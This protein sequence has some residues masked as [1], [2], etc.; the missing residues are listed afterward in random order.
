MGVRVAH[1]TLQVCHGISTDALP[2]VRKSGVTHF[3][4]GVVHNM[5]MGGRVGNSAGMSWYFHRCAMPTVRES[6][7]THFG[8][9]AVHMSVR[10]AHATL[11]V[12]HGIS[13]DA[14]RLLCAKE[15]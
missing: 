1:A 14:L 6:G 7:V 10:V 12:C 9:G 4:K 3:G 2:T 5:A 11:Q 15:V 8:K 13:T